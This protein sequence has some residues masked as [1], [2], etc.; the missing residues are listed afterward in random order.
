MNFVA[1]LL[2]EDYWLVEN[3]ARYRCLDK[4]LPHKAALLSHLRARWQDLFAATFDVLLYDLTSTYFESP[5]PADEADKRRHGYSRDKRGDCVQ[6]VIALV[7]TPDGFP[8]GY[9]VLPGNTA[10]CTTLRDMLR[11]VEAHTARPT[12]SG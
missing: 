6:V 5:P 12:A 7:V 8:L 2:G 10:D 11:K 1:D 9:E 4:L 3:N